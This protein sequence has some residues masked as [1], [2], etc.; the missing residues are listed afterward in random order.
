MFWPRL[1][2]LFSI[3]PF[4]ILAQTTG[5]V[6]PIVEVSNGR[7]YLP[8]TASVAGVCS[9]ITTTIGN[10]VDYIPVPCADTA[11]G[12]IWSEEVLVDGTT[13]E[14]IIAPSGNVRFLS[15]AWR[16]ANS[17][18]STVISSRNKSSATITASS[19][20]STFSRSV[21]FPYPGRNSTSVAINSTSISAISNYQNTNSSSGS[22][23]TSP[24]AG[25]SSYATS[26]NSNSANSSRTSNLPHG[27][28]S[29]TP[30]STSFNST[31]GTITS[32]TTVSSTSTSPVATPIVSNQI[33][34][35]AQPNSNSRG[36]PLSSSSTM[37]NS[38]PQG[39]HVPAKNPAAGPSTGSTSGSA[40]SIYGVAAALSPT[41]S[42]SSPQTPTITPPLKSS[43]SA[44]GSFTPPISSD[45]DALAPSGPSLLTLSMSGQSIVLKRQTMSGFEDFTGTT[46]VTASE[47]TTNTAGVVGWA[48][49][50]VIIGT[51]GVFWGLY[52]GSRTGRFCIW[53]F[54]SGG[55]GFCIWPFCGG[56]GGA[57]GGG[58]GGGEDGDPGEE[59]PDESI[60]TMA[61]TT[62][63]ES[64]TTMATTTASALACP[65]FSIPS[66][67]LTND[68]SPTWNPNAPEYNG[69]IVSAA[70]SIWLIDSGTGPEILP[71]LPTSTGFG[72]GIV[73]AYIPN[74][75]GGSNSTNGS[76]TTTAMLTPTSASSASYPLVQ[77]S[78]QS[79]FSV[80]SM[81]S[82]ASVQSLASVES[83][84][85]AKSMATINSIASAQSA[86][87][88]ESAAAAQS[89]AL[90]NSIALVQSVAS[91]QSVA[92]AKSAAVLNSIASAQSVASVASALSAANVA[93]ALSASSSA[94]AASVASLPSP[95]PNLAILIIRNDYCDDTTCS[96]TGYVYDI[97]P[98][99][100]TVPICS[101]PRWIH[102]FSYSEDVSTETGNYPIDSGKF[103]SH[104]VYTNCEYQGSS[105]FLGLFGC[106]QI[107]EAVLCTEPTEPETSCSDSHSLDADDWVP[108]VYCEVSF[109]LI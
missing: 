46:T 7:I 6:V 41:T 16:D 29:L 19:T 56:T 27:V 42:S 64:I 51:G 35:S 90:I 30:Q 25:P 58:G 105:G 81:E 100:P 28:P 77:G 79:V 3:T 49:G 91:V 69:D 40:T 75:G 44:P 17:T 63:Y 1:C 80:E 48:T 101:N 94:S 67:S 33:S 104:G 26:A 87:S 39:S 70:Y 95:T 61:K 23:S 84:A 96:S 31:S 85:A 11:H 14:L 54:C 8:S 72:D 2:L 20:A 92:A 102:S 73:I 109:L 68:G 36:S 9:T 78:V 50:A 13:A 89:A 59:D 10:N 55:G 93:S 108:I 107:I 21:L 22:N 57:E 52:V 86:A 47:K 82:V 24:R 34:S 5:D 38:T 88:V 60:T 32:L 74:A 4:R 65:L 66:D 83:V 12:S 98:S 97:V 62:A 103:T 43:A 37:S 18:R 53:P 45:T 71:P 15:E 99:S 76:S 106:D